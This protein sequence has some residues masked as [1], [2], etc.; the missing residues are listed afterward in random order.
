MKQRYASGS[1]QSNSKRIWPIFMIFCLFAYSISFSQSKIISGKVINHETDEPLP[2][3]NIGIANKT[4]GTVSGADG[5]FSLRISDIITGLATVIFSYVGFVSKR[6]LISELDKDHNTITISPKI[7]AL[8]ELVFNS[9]KIKLKAKKIGRSSAGL[10]LTH[11][12]FYTYGEE[13][14]DDRLS[15]EKGMKLT[16]KRNCHIQALNFNV[17]SND[18]KSLKFRVNFY[19]IKNGLP[20][21]LL[22]EKNIVFEIR[23][24][25]LGWFNV[26][27][28]PYEIYIDQRVEAFAATIQW[29][30]SV[31]KTEKSKYFSISTIA[32][33]IHKAYF[34]EKAMDSWQTGGQS[35]SFYLS[36]LCE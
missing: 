1:S 22:L 19:T 33:P 27:L 26:D 5:H 14:V 2:F 29:L 16:V 36:A 17:T 7:T 12:N 4:T 8:K 6:Y 30:E 24:G 13:T 31:K 35:L 23:D 25:F 21:D 10:G 11:T 9:K 3:V 28:A 20:A 18:F 32:S 15:K 34:R